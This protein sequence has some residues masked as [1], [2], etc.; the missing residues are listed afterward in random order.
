MLE[1]QLIIEETLPLFVFDD[2]DDA[3]E[4]TEEQVETLLGPLLA[5]LIVSGLWLWMP[6]KL[7]LLF[8]S[9]ATTAAAAEEA[10]GSLLMLLFRRI[11]FMIS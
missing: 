3:V 7:L 9:R 8:A 5:L 11:V 4:T 1:V 6:L 10:K 2:N